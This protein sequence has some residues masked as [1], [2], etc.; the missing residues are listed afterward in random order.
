MPYDSELARVISG[1]FRSA[2]SL[3]LDATQRAGFERMLQILF[4]IRNLRNVQLWT[5]F[6]A[7]TRDFINRG[8]GE[9]ELDLRTFLASKFI[10]NVE[11]TFPTKRKPFQMPL[12]NV[13]VRKFF[14]YITDNFIREYCTRI[15]V[16]GR[17]IIIEYA[18]D[19]DTPAE[20][21]DL[22]SPEFEDITE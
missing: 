13:A 12:D 17:F 16:E 3:R 6:G 7:Q 4:G 22:D 11:P 19:S 8:L 18:S 15:F 9:L 1:Q 14:E 21:P 20:T 2:V 5:R 10:N